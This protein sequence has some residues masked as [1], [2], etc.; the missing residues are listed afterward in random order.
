MKPDKLADESVAHAIGNLSERELIR[1]HVDRTVAF[2][3]QMIREQEE[4]CRKQMAD[5][6]ASLKAVNWPR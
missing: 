1:Q 4:R 3:R 5:V 2:Q 6:K